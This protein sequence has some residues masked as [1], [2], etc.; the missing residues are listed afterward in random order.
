MSSLWSLR[1]LGKSAVVRHSVKAAFRLWYRHGSEHRIAR[2]PIA[3]M[4]WYCH[5]HHQFWMPLGVYEAE[6]AQWISDA[7]QPG[8]C[9]FDVGANAGYFTLLGSRCVTTTGRVEAFEPV[10]DN[11]DV[12]QRQI[13]LNDLNNV[14][15]RN[16]ALAAETGT[17]E[18]VVERVNANSH[19]GSVQLTHAREDATDRLSVQTQTMDEFVQSHGCAPDVIKI[20]VEGAEMH[21]LNGATETLR[22]ARPLLLVSTHS[23]SLKEE[24]RALLEASG[25]R[26]S[27]LAT[28]EHELVA[29][30]VT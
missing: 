22:E 4:R 10:P 7:L 2:G 3:G 23:A 24:C 19:L 18:F 21:V 5:R 14:H 15:L 9:F 16:V 13:A 25:Y 6:T 28:F 11:I 29:E 17:A 20:D 1:W 8:M 26:V 12:V 27:T 30:P